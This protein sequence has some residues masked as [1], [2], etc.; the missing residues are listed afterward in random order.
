MASSV[1]YVFHDLSLGGLAVDLR[2]LSSGL[3][4]RGWDVTVATMSPTRNGT[5]S[6][7]F[8]PRVRL[9]EL[10]PLPPQRVTRRVGGA[11]GIRGLIRT[12]RPSIVHVIS[13]LPNYLHFAAM[14]S[15]KAAGSTL[16][17]TP[18]MHPDRMSTWRE[19]PRA[20]GIPMAVF[21]SVAPRVCRWADAV[22][23]ATAA[24]AEFFRRLNAPRVHLVPPAVERL[25]RQARGSRFRSSIGVG[26]RPMILVVAGR[27][28]RRKGVDFAREVG[29]HLQS[30]I[31]GGTMVITGAIAPSSVSNQ[32][33]ILTGSLSD[34][35]LRRVLGEAD[36]VFVPSRFEAFSR[37]VIE[38]WQH[39]RPVVVSDGVGLAPTVAMGGGLVVRYGDVSAAAEALRDLILHPDRAAAMGAWGHSHV[40][41]NYLLATIV[42][43]TEQIY[44]D[45]AQSTRVLVSAGADDGRVI[46]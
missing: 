15:A 24:E 32:G 2:N 26:D 20:I 10:H 7:A 31:P 16:V 14:R 37:V 28:E 8:D 34:A 22:L 17:W 43:R 36:V 30:L 23:A 42:A 4:E 40:H 21:D 5:H 25:R 46:P 1:L 41:S 39:R 11:T 27:D 45:L 33:V 44:E 6:V 9:H 13:C 18:M 38:A 12:S 19:Y 29:R 35:D 3:S